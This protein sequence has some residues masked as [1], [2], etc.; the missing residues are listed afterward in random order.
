[1]AI[2]EVSHIRQGESV[3]AVGTATYEMK[4]KEGISQRIT[5]RWTDVRRKVDGR[6]VYVMDHAHALA[7]D[8]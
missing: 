6:W 8:Q 4:T 5:E 3:F 2:D 1:L 7:P